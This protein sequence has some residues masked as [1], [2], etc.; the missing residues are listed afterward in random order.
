MNTI[1][2]F[3]EP[4]QRFS[5]RA[6]LRENKL[7]D[8]IIVG[9]GSVGAG[10]L[11][12][13]TLRGYKTL[14]IEK[15]DYAEGTSSR[16]SKLLH[17]GLR[18][19]AQGNI[20][21]IREALHERG[22][23]IN[24]APFVAQKSGFLIPCYSWWKA[25]YFRFG[26]FIYD[27]LSGKMSIGKA[28]FVTGTDKSNL[29]AKFSSSTSMVRYYDGI[30]DDARLII[31]LIN[32]AID[33]G[34]MAI[35]HCSVTSVVE[36]ENE[37]SVTALDLLTD[38]KFSLKAKCVI[39]T[40]GVWSEEL[41]SNT[42][43]EKLAGM[44][45]SRGSHIVLDNV[46]INEA[47]LF[48]KTPDGRVLFIIP[49]RNKTLIGTTDVSEKSAPMHP[50]VSEEDINWLIETA[51]SILAKPISRADIRGYFIGYRPLVNPR[52]NTQVSSSKISREHLIEMTS[53]HSARI[54]GGKWT[55]YR[56]MAAEVLD[57][58][59][60]NAMLPFLKEC[61]TTHFKLK[62]NPIIDTNSPELDFEI[63]VNS[64][65]QMQK[66]IQSAIESEG[67]CTIDDILSRR[68]RTSTTNFNQAN[69][70]V[71]VVAEVMAK[72]ANWSEEI[73]A[74]AINEARAK[75]KQYQI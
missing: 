16:S 7:W 55:T 24:N 62:A 25:C 23:V 71:E 45:V 43:R 67:A 42:L 2:A 37:N 15:Q 58:T 26:L 5:T 34:A 72:L 6:T 19:L 4:K 64:S 8:L 28:H 27:T 54:I 13:A 17:G 70:L 29:L 57:Y 47:V 30:F 56:K 60:N 68:V 18:Y 38:E 35:N 65:E 22:L 36:D 44:R 50:P 10:L 41:L 40:T 31:S 53:K 61:Q 14:L 11:L 39:H 63:P 21:L 52:K 9:G 66:F 75:L 69:N 46:G 1:E 49:W 48:P 20:K 59:I 3:V 51:N 32:T 12:D 73:K 74:K 33:N